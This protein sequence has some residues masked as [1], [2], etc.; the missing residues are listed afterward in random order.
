MTALQ[1]AET[2]NEQIDPGAESEDAIKDEAPGFEERN[3]RVD[4]I[5]GWIRGAGFGGP[6]SRLAEGRARAAEK[7][8]VG[9]RW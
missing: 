7:G 4:G 5:K 2:L 6:V 8:G 1:E 9:L 3:S